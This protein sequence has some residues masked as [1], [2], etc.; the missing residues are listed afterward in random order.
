M[1]SKKKAAKRS[2]I[3]ATVRREHQAHEKLSQQ[4]AQLHTPH[5]KT[6]EAS[7]SSR[8]ADNF[9]NPKKSRTVLSSADAAEAV[10]SGN[11]SRAA[12][13]R[14]LGDHINTRLQE[15]AFEDDL[16]GDVF[17]ER[18]AQLMEEAR[19]AAGVKQ[20]DMSTSVRHYLGHQAEMHDL[21][22]V[23]IAHNCNSV[24]C[25]AA[26]GTD[27]IVYGDKSGKVYLVDISLAT[28][29]AGMSVSDKAELQRR[30]KVLLEPVLP[31][32]IVS[33]AVSDTTANRPTARDVFEKTTVDMSC[34]SYV[35]AGAMDGSISVWETLTK[36]HKGLLFMHRKPITGLQF[37]MDTATLYSSCEDGTLRVWAVPQMIAVDKLFGHEGPAHFLDCLRKE[38]AVTVG[39]DGTMRFWKM[40]A[41]T[42]QAYNYAPA[43]LPE[44][45]FTSDAAASPP[46]PP[47]VVMDTVAMLNESIIVAGARDGAVVVFDVNRRKPLVVVPAAHGYGF[48]GDGTG[49]EK[50]AAQLAEEDN[51]DRVAREHA[52]A[53][54]SGT[55]E[56]QRRNP[57]PI[58]AVA[59]VPYADVVATGSYDGVVRVWHVVGVGAGATAP[60]KRTDDGQNGD[61]APPSGKWTE[62]QLVLVTELPVR[63]IVNS[64][65]FCGN[66]DVLLIAVAK[67][68]RRGRWVVQS[69]ARNGVL[70]VPLTESGRKKLQGVRGEVEH[71]PAQLFGIDD[72]AA[73]EDAAGEEA[74]V[75]EA[76]AS[77]ADLDSSGELDA[78]DGADGAG[79]EDAEDVADM[80]DVG[81]DG[82][83]RFRE[84]VSLAG[85]AAITSKKRKKGKSGMPKVLR[86]SKELS[87]VTVAR[88]SGSAKM[89]KA[90]S[91]KKVKRVEAK[92]KKL[93]ASNT[94]VA[95]SKKA[96]KRAK[97]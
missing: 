39:E 59:A 45:S 35:A 79:R 44:K 22:S 29:G 96:M 83:M 49:L 19:L 67:E 87:D 15:V 65:R 80:F 91:A 32:G 8:G 52:T 3:S 50:A 10:G 12:M 60:G 5:K 20:R 37:R 63:A 2:A 86:Q 77:E 56:A 70:L 66:G 24:T 76:D 57:N 1:L 74:H 85:G 58:I 78:S 41:A 28:S 36:A 47:A 89:K 62:P 30:R 18:R 34:P 53:S 93:H 75:N 7:A 25:V 97:A 55:V 68:P 33:I 11:G 94:V 31:S 4:N 38:T 26:L 14:S 46:P 16:D 40:D 82:M 92:S 73:E 17:H 51:G 69:S 71:I 42:Q 72:A 64:L 9:V 43:R 48:I 88:D 13:I 54:S 95:T 27:R 23:R 61:A 81:P 84:G 21:H 90:L 6:A